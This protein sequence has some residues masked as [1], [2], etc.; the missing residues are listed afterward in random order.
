MELEDLSIGSISA[1]KQAQ[2]QSKIAVKVIKGI[3]EQSE[4]VMA[5][6]VDA[7]KSM[8]APESGKGQRLNIVA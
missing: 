5:I 3:N 2:A 4:A 1:L 6:I 8:P 7:I